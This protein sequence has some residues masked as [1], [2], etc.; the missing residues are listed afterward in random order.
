MTLNFFKSIRAK[1]AILF[2]LVFLIVILPVHWLVY[3]KVE[4]ALVETNKRELNVE[5]EK[6]LGQVRLDPITIPI[7]AEG[8]VMKLQF[9]KSIQFETIFSSPDFPELD[10]L[11]FWQDITYTDT[12]EIV[13]VRR[14]LEQQDAS[15][16]LSL[17][18]SGTVFQEQL[19]SLQF[20]LFAAI[21][22]AIA[23]AGVLVYF[24]SGWILKP[25]KK[26]A[27][28]SSFVNSSKDI[29]L[30][31][32]P[33]TND[34]SRLLAESINSMLERIRQSANA[35]TNFFA[36]AA[37]ELRTPLAVMKAELT[38]ANSEAAPTRINSLLQEVER[39]ERVIHDFLLISE[40][41]AEV[42]SIRKSKEGLDELI[43]ASLKKIKYTSDAYKTLVQLMIDDGVENFEVNVDADKMETIIVN[44]VENAIKYSPRHSTVV[45]RLTKEGDDI[46]IEVSNPIS[47]PIPD[48]TVFLQE[49][50]KSGELSS[51]LGM[52]LWI[53][54][55]IVKLHGFTL[56][57][58]SN[59]LEFKAILHIKI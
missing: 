40:L 48:P 44:L 1:T 58:K 5:A 10:M 46:L 28:A 52:G 23:S 51:G 9:Q 20:Y 54:D 38:I 13:N 12:L 41:K 2:F 47:N 7:P 4:A 37:H 26:I 55:Q 8:F 6:L 27:L 21:I 14:A 50:N 15:L 11:E 29:N 16:I 43:Y 36:S 49:F 33:Q 59:G 22:M 19:N 30:I 3:K 31:P 39:L 57:L 18:R 24:V 35:Q 45:L 42:L 53:C 56:A 25:I 17:G 34:E 32:L